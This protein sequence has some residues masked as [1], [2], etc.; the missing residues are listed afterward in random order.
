MEINV[1]LHHSQG[2]A[3]RGEGGLS[4]SFCK[5]GVIMDLIKRI[6][7]PCKRIVQGLGE[8]YFLARGGH[9]VDLDDDYFGYATLPQDS[10][11]NDD[12][13]LL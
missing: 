1:C 10:F 11:I 3:G 13:F 6:T 8:Q 2:R 4:L 9:W 7:N 12:F 5:M